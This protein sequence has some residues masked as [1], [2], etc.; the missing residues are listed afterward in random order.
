VDNTVTTVTRGATFSAYLERFDRQ[1]EHIADVISPVRIRT[2]RKGAIVSSRL[3][4]LQYILIVSAIVAIIAA[5]L[6]D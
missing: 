1:R 3:S 4:N 5:R 6:T 2:G